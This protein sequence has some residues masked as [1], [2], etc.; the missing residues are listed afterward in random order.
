MTLKSGEWHFHRVGIE[1]RFLGQR[2]KREV[3]AAYTI[4]LLSGLMGKKN[5]PV[6]WHPDGPSGYKQKHCV[7]S[8]IGMEMPWVR[9]VGSGTPVGRLKLQKERLHTVAPVPKLRS[10]HLLSPGPLLL[11]LCVQLSL[12]HC[13][14]SAGPF[15]VLSSLLFQSHQSSL[16]AIILHFNCTTNPC[17]LWLRFP[18]IC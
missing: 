12:R 18:P 16:H 11:H 15:S 10:R 17:F 14:T 9:S 8:A 7:C 3:M 13:W 4:R 5:W 1:M 6:V 2:K